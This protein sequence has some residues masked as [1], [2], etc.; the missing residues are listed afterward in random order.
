MRLS[1]LDIGPGLQNLD[2]CE[3]LED[4]YLAANRIER[5]GNGFARN[6]NLQILIL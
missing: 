2:F 6:Y 3:A 5:I 1:F 4:A